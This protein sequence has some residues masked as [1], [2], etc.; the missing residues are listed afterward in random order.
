[1]K[2]E[3]VSQRLFNTVRSAVA[4]EHVALQLEIY[5]LLVDEL[6]REMGDLEAQLATDD[7][8]FSGADDEDMEDEQ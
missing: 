4:R 6:D 8:K 7:E 1:M 5:Q 3:Q 2:A